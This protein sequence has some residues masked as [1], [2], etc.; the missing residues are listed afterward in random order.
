MVQLSTND[1]R[2]TSIA[3]CVLT[4]ERPRTLEQLL[5]EVSTMRVPASY[6]AS[7][8]LIDNSP[9][10]ED[11]GDRSCP[12]W[13][14]RVVDEPRQGIARARN[15]AVAEAGDVDL[16]VFFDDDERPRP[17]TLEQL[18]DVYEQSGAQVV[19]GCS[20]PD[21]EADP[22]QWVLDGEYFARR[23]GG[24]SVPI[25]PYL[26]RTSNVLIER[27]V[28]DMIQPPFDERLQLTGG[29]DS[30]LFRSLAERGVNFVGTDLAV[31][32]EWIPEARMT[33]EWLVRRNYQV[34]FAVSVHLRST[35]PGLA[36]KA[37]RVARAARMLALAPIH[38][39]S[40]LPSGTARL[41]AG[42]TTAYAIGLIVGISGRMPDF[43]R[44]R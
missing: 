26:A 39:L 43:Y 30:F 19:Q 25:P 20:V 16:I 17:D 38:G 41:R 2:E 1:A 21:F 11:K 32:D 13:E 7:L 18:I 27:S 9:D 29:E 22:P 4:F 6:S 24:P 23:F 34:G 10:F 5:A 42:R 15:R 3:V 35:Q 8:I 28:L 12:G 37:K 33:R 44:R 14:V 40:G 31:V 36:R